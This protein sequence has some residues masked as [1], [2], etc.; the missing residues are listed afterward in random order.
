MRKASVISS[1]QAGHL[2]MGFHQFSETEAADYIDDKER[3]TWRDIDKP[4]LSF[5]PSVGNG[6][7]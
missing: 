5:D 7:A 3:L 6:A 2:A 4:D 1:G